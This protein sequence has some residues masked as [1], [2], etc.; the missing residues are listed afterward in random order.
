[1]TSENNLSLCSV[2]KPANSVT[3]IIRLWLLLVKKER[4]KPTETKTKK[5]ANEFPV[6]EERGDSGTTT[7]KNMMESRSSLSLYIVIKYC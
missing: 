6:G 5:N 2:H 7:A 4:E 3:C 1:M